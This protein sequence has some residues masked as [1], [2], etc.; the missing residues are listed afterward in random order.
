MKYVVIDEHNFERIASLIDYH[1]RHKSEHANRFLDEDLKIVADILDA[2][3][4][5]MA[6][7]NFICPS[8]IQGAIEA[9]QKVDH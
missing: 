1:C 6:Y 8:I 5:N 9:A 3:S 4:E 7:E 2:F